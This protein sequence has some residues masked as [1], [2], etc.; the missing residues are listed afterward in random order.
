MLSISRVII[1]MRMS[2][3]RL[4]SMIAIRWYDRFG[5][6]TMWFCLCF[7]C[8]VLKRRSIYVCAVLLGLGS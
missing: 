6:Y 3:V 2:V 4:L 8:N 7:F 5:L 1:K